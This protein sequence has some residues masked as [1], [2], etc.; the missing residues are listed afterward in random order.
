MDAE[1]DDVG[2]RQQVAERVHR[3]RVLAGLTVVDAARAAGVGRTKWTEVEAGQPAKLETLARIATVVGLDPAELLSI[4][5]S[6]WRRD[7]LP[8]RRSCG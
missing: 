7:L 8:I 6:V 4:C 5:L 3:A 1:H 2:A